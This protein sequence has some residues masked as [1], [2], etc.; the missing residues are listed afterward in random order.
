MSGLIGR[1]CRMREGRGEGKIRPLVDD[2]AC[3]TRG[4]YPGNTVVHGTLPA[5]KPLG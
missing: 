4:H 2:P 3:R 1:V 5:R